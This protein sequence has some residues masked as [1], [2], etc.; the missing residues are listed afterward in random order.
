MIFPLYANK[1][2]SATSD[3]LF[4]ACLKDKILPKAT[5]QKKKQAKFHKN[6]RVPYNIK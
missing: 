5:S 2:Y 4:L 6:G 3:P 1:T